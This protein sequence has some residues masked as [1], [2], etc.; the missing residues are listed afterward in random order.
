MNVVAQLYQ[1]VERR[2]R[3][4]LGFRGLGSSAYFGYLI[5]K[6]VGLL[7]VSRDEWL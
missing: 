5:G 3:R 7:K 4:R 2:S 6:K 1:D